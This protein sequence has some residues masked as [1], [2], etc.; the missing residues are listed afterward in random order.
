MPTTRTILILS[1]GANLLLTGW[2]AAKLSRR[3]EALPVPAMDGSSGEA[4]SALLSPR[5]LRTNVTEVT[6]NTV[7]APGFR[8][9]WI[10]TNDFRAFAAN[11]RAIG[12]PQRTIRDILLPDIEKTYGRR[13]HALASVP[14]PFWQNAAQ[15]SSRQRERQR[16]Q[17][18]ADQERVTLLRELTGAEWSAAAREIWVDEEEVFF[19]LGYLSDEKAMP[20]LGLAERLERLGDTLRHEMRDIT[21]DEDIAQLREMGRTIQREVL[22]HLTPTEA[23][24][25]SLR[26]FDA[27]QDELYDD[28]RLRGVELSGFEHRELLRL[29]TQGRDWVSDVLVAALTHDEG[30]LENVARERPENFEAQAR[31]L[32]GDARF[33]AYERSQDK[34]FQQL[35]QSAEDGRLPESVAIRAYDIRMSALGEARVLA[36]HAGSVTPELRKQALDSIH[37]ATTQA[38]TELY[39]PKEGAERAKEF[40]RAV[41]KAANKGQ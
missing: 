32:L 14:E 24:E 39:G 27:M 31:A 5:L 30:S 9:A 19:T 6:T 35:M 34:A 28:H 40:R 12:C 13:K 33:A 18:A 15:V 17:N 11:L 3:A 10:E 22:G 20:V 36:E 29:A 4:E 1:L 21:D 26:G 38:L 16:A 8:W 25:L 7:D 23:E 37:A 41:E 2:L